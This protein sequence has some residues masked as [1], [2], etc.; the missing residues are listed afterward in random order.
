[1]SDQGKG[2]KP[3][4][5]T[6]SSSVGKWEA[7]KPHV[8]LQKAIRHLKSRIVGAL[9]KAQVP[10]AGKVSA[11]KHGF[12][13]GYN[14]SPAQANLLHGLDWSSFQS[15]GS[16][17]TPNITEDVGHIGSGAHQDRA[18]VKSK[19][20]FEE[21]IE[22][23][24]AHVP[25]DM[26]EF[27]SPQREV[28]YHNVGHEVFGMG[29]FIPTTAGFKHN[30][31]EYSAMKMVEGR[32]PRVRV[33][34]MHY[35][36]QPKFQNKIAK[37]VLRA[38]ALGHD[39]PDHLSII[40]HAFAGR[41]ADMGPTSPADP[42]MS[43]GIARSSLPPTITQSIDPNYRSTLRTLGNSGDLHKLALM[44]VIM[45][46][47]DRHNGNVLLDRK[48]PTLHMIDHGGAF[49]YSHFHMHEEPSYLKHHWADNFTHEEKIHPEANAWLQG[50]DHSQAKQVLLRHHGLHADH[51]IVKTF[52]NRLDAAKAHAQDDK[53]FHE[54]LRGIRAVKA[55]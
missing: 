16:V 49:D 48:S 1:M 19:G 28:L 50:I 52:L 5:A 14:S 46:N 40:K 41:M 17:S 7:L 39:V 55:V 18:I 35:I 12:H 9:A 38:K 26:K 34:P 4:D 13:E 45:G 15:I 54:V 10:V 2:K 25:K 22:N 20:G 51:P 53:P 43:L 32:K 33:I 37:D 42:Q 8:R 47:N 23:Q 31:E 29:K 11:T 6:P 36:M 21:G 3:F 27:G 44:N 30:G 24:G